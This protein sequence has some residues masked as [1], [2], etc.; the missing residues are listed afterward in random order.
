MCLAHKQ[1]EQG[2]TQQEIR[3]KIL[4]LL[5]DGERHMITEL[6]NIRT[7]QPIDDDKIVGKTLKTLL[8]EEEVYMDGS[9]I[10]LNGKGNIN[11]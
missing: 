1:E 3:E 6:K 7:D 2:D 4:N 9:Y 8:D 11:N 10:Q 5:A